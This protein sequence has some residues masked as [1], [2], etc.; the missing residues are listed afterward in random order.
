MKTLLKIVVVIVAFIP[1]SV[2]AQSDLSRLSRSFEALSQK[3][4]PAV[5]QVF[6]TGYSSDETGLS[7]ESLLTRQRSSGSGVIIDPEGYVVTNAHVVQGALRVQVLLNTGASDGSPGNSIL[8]S[9]GKVVPAAILGLDSETDIALLRIEGGS[10][11]Y[12][13]LGD[14]DVLRPGQ[15]VLAFGSPFGLENSVTMGVVSAIARQLRTEDPMIYIQTDAPINPGNSGGPLVDTEGRLMGINTIIYSNSG[16]NEG[17]GFAAPSNIVKN[18]VQQIRN[19]GRV[20]R[21]EIGANVQSITPALAGGLGLK[22]NWGVIVS[23]VA[24][25][26]PAEKAGLQS[27]DLILTM[28][29]KVMENGRQFD[30]N[31]YRRSEGETVTL[32][33]LRGDRKQ[34]VDVNVMFREEDIDSIPELIRPETSLISTLGVFGVTMNDQIAELLPAIK[35][36]YGVVV[37]G[38]AADAP[39]WAREFRAGDIIHALNGKFITSV[40]QLRTALDNLRAGSPVALQVE[41]RSRLFYVAFEVE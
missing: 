21:G 33:Y 17:V 40:E 31:L 1:L 10:L 39:Y 34:A 20:R 14:S 12:L 29:G 38:R 22:Q 35:K 6:V 3:V 32:E 13:E 25:G 16:G 11:P 15:L 26:S 2:Y 18:V 30:V 36:Q 23:D 37:V 27:G 28:D 7:S 5:V 41:R 8:K 9:R 24:P 4:G 19:S